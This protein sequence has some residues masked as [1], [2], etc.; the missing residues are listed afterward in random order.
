MTARRKGDDPASATSK[1]LVLG[2]SAGGRKTGPGTRRLM[3]AGVRTVVITCLVYS[4]MV[5]LFTTVSLFIAPHESQVGTFRSVATIPSHELVL[6][7]LGLVLGLAVS[8][9]LRKL[10]LG[11]V[12]LIPALVVLTD[13]DHLPSYFSLAQPIRPAHS[14]IFILVTVAVMA[15]VIRR[16][17]IELASLSAFFAHLSID[18]GVFP[19]FSPISFQY[20]ALSQFTIPFLAAA[21]SFAVAAGLVNNHRRK[22]VIL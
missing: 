11:F 15:M 13:L 18:T 2:A 19:P 5:L 22:K 6:V 9:V 12:I 16:T 8:V 21:V 4:A 17:D 14:I 10:D 3:S 7:L 1:D 20:Y